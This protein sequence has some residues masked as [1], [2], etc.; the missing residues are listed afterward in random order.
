MYFDPKNPMLYKRQNENDNLC[1]LKFDKSV[2]DLDGVVVSDRNASSKYATF[3]PPEYG[4][5]EIDFDMVYASDWTDP[6]QYIYWNK[7]STKCAEVL[8]PHMVS[9]KYVVCA[10]VCNEIAK[11][12]LEKTGFDKTIYEDRRFF[13]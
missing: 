1:I 4:L 10:A 2:L 8:V 13:F 3:Y 6:N 5:Q 11:L 9:F 12:K 7:K